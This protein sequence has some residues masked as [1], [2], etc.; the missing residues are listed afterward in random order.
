M[1]PDELRYAT[2]REQL[3]ER[4]G[5]RR[6]DKICAM[7]GGLSRDQLADRVG[8]V[9]AAARTGPPARRVPPPVTTR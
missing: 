7:A 6:F 3:E 1:A 4:L 2:L 5:G 9:L 8:A